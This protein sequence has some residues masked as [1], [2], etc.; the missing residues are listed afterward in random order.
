MG[1]LLKIVL[2]FLV[3]FWVLR[4]VSRL[5]FGGLFRQSQQAGNTYQQQDRSKNGQVY[6][7]RPHRKERSTRDFKGGEY[8][9]YEE[10]K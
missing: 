8:I 9:D 2:F 5:M 4:A 7:D 3:F 10:V 6:E 1:P